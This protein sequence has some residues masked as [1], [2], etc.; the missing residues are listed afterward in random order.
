MARPS[1]KLAT[2]LEVLKTLQD[3]GFV[4]IRSRDLTRTHRERLVK[5][6]FLQPGPLGIARCGSCCGRWLHKAAMRLY[7]FQ[8][9]ALFST[10]IPVSLPEINADNFGQ[11]A[12]NILAVNCDHGYVI[13]IRWKVLN[14][15][16]V[17]LVAVDTN[18]LKL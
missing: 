12:G 9:S 11:F 2:S 18:C 5:H 15:I 13:N 14:H 1:E 17:S 7:F 3:T 8:P 6:S 16:I 4:A 10:R